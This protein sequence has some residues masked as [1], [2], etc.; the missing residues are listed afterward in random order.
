[1]DIKSWIIGY[2]TG[3]IVGITSYVCVKKW[4]E[5]KVRRHNKKEIEWANQMVAKIKGIGA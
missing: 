2:T 1:M 4:H 5:R 3:A